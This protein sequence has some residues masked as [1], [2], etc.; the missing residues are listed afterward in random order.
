MGYST[1]EIWIPCDKQ[2][3]AIGSGLSGTITAVECAEQSISRGV[4]YG[5]SLRASAAHATNSAV[6]VKL[7]DASGG[8]LL[9]STTANLSSLTILADTLPAPIPV[10][11]TPFFQIGAVGSSGSTITFTIRFFI[12]AMA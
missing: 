10:F 3:E 12:K 7:Y 2:G 8:D 1:K 6:P 5:Y 4:V 11:A 9:Y